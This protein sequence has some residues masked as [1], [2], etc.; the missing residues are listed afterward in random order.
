ADLK[1][2]QVTT[3]KNIFPDGEF[4]SRN[5][6]KLIQESKAH[7]A[8]ADFQFDIDSTLRV[9]IEP[10][11][12]LT[13]RKTSLIQNEITGENDTDITSNADIENYDENDHNRF[14]NSLNFMKKFKQ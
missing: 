11:F 4:Y 14:T 10:T 6:S 1:N 9:I 12:N 13:K 2:S 5:E 3:R 8:D 7:R